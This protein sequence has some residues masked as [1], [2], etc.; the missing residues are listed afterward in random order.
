MELTKLGKRNRR[1]S[2]TLIG[3]VAVAV[4]L[5]LCALMMTRAVRFQGE[6]RGTTESRDAVDVAN[7]GLAHARVNLVA[8]NSQ[9]IGSADEPFAFGG[10]TYWVTVE[11]DD[12]ES[13]YNV[14]SNATVRD[15]RASVLGV[16]DAVSSDIYDNAMFAGNSSGD[17]DYVLELGGSGGQADQIGGDIYSGGDV[18]VTGTADVSGTIRATGD[19]YGAGGET[20][21]T[22]LV[23]DLAGQ[24][25]ETSADFDVAALFA[26]NS[27]YRYANA[28]GYADQVPE[29]NPAHIFRRNPSDRTSE[30]SGTAKNDYFLEDPYEPLQIDRN[31]DGSDAYGI[32]LSGVSG[33]PGTNGNGKVYFIDGN[34]WIHNRRSYSF[35]FRHNEA[36][37]VQVTFVV[38]GNIYFSD[39]LFYGNPE[40]DG[41]VFIAMKDSAVKDSGNIY[42]GDPA[43]G[44]LQQMNAFMYAENDFYDTNLDASGSSSVTLHGNMTAGN[45]VMIERDYGN[46]HT[47]LVID[48]DDRISTGDLMMPGLPSVASDEASLDL[49]LWRRSALP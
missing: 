14:T 17:P 41:A 43:F 4:L 22:Q 45:H 38:K 18:E 21:G 15:T 34:L 47:Q 35:A 40:V 19:I 7:A 6:R 28:G 2:A 27:A 42:F 46:S 25:Y 24:N 5:S 31:Q 23:P 33:E 39:N 11:Y 13:V 26:G 20:G 29:A 1:G 44:T 36:N 12:A 10:G 37:G 32:S 48:F 49:V 3:V 30:T 16:F 9:N 8:G